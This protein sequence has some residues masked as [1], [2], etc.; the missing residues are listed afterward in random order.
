MMLSVAFARGSRPAHNAG[1]DLHRR[2]GSLTMQ[3][4]V[5][6]SLGRVALA[7]RQA[8]GRW[9]PAP[10]TAAISPVVLSALSVGLDLARALSSRLDPVGLDVSGAERV[11]VDSGES[12]SGAEASGDALRTPL[13]LVVWERLLVPSAER[14]AELR[15]L[16][17]YDA[18][19]RGLVLPIPAESSLTSPREAL[20]AP[21]LAVDG[22]SST[23]SAEAGRT[24]GLVSTHLVRAYPGT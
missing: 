23:P 8:G 7:R 17:T 6:S 1:S 11:P 9:L 16:A 4:R 24:T 21:A 19:A 10:R 13:D 2:P 20:G 3:C 14:R 18:D 5:G 15:R 12:A 22:G